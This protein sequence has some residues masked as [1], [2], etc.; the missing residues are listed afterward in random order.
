M[1]KEIRL[2]DFKPDEHVLIVVRHHWFIFF[3]DII[4]IALL[5]FVPFFAVPILGIFIT[6]GG[7]QIPTGFGFFFASFWAL[8]LWQMLFARW[9]DYYYDIWIVTNWRIIDVDQKGFFNRDTATLFNF[10]QIQDIS[11]YV[12]TVIGTFLDYGCIQIQTAAA[13]REFLFKSVSNPRHVERVIR[14]AQEKFLG[15]KSRL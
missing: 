12:D 15:L 13:K 1:K 9:T 4:G 3:K 6:A 10:E 2:K 7:L 5:F 11:T 8:I 14:N